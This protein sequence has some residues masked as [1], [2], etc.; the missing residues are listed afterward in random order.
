[1]YPGEFETLFRKISNLF[2]LETIAKKEII[3]GKLLKRNPQT[4]IWDTI[5]S[6]KGYDGIDIGDKRYISSESFFR[7]PIRILFFILIHELESRLYR[8]H[9]WNGVPLKELDELN[10]NDLI[11]D[12]VDNKELLSLQDIYPSRTVFKEDLKAL[13]SFRNIIMHTNRKLQ[14]GIDDITIIKRKK[15][16]LSLLE[17]LQ[18]ILDRMDRKSYE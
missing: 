10:I 12:I 3:Q 15:Q 9:R 4:P 16:I 18:Q 13:S 7:K 8:I 14:K 2:N 5:D 6:I 11:R 17:A 1:M